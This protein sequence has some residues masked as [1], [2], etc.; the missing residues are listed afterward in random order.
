MPSD[1]LDI[2][3]TRHHLYVLAQAN[4]LTP[5]ALE[6]ALRMIGAL[7]NAYAWRRFIDQAL[8]LLGTALLSAGVIFFFAYNWANMSYFA[9]FGLLE[10][11]VLTLVSFVAWRGLDNL[12]GK[13]TLLAASLLLG[14]LLAVYGQ[15]Y[16][17]GA[18]AF[19]LFLSWALLIVPWVLLGA[20]ASLWLL[21]WGLFNLSL[22]LYWGQVMDPSAQLRI[23]LFLFLFVLN[24]MALLAW[25]VAFKL[26]VSWL[27]GSWLGR[28][29]FCVTLM[30]LI[31]PTIETIV[32]FESFQDEMLSLQSWAVALYLATTAAALWYYH[33]RQR[34]LFLLAVCLLGILIMITTFLGKLLPIQE[35]ATWL[36][37]AFVV[38]GQTVYATNWLQ[39]VA[40]NWEN[41]K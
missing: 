24:G 7:P 38:I 6:Y 9:K 31:I 4:H 20:F 19:T 29:L 8:L 5:A 15:A 1:P 22:I 18:D 37:L 27:Q 13:T 30:V 28:I 35:V 33:Y 26:G 41:Q 25:E 36:L 23:L 40:H 17:T 10:V 3:A 11:G 34:D 39:G 32:D 14:V 16:Q 2:P 21:L 12:S